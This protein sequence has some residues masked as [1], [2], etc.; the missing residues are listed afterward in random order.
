VNGLLS[1]HYFVNQ[2]Q[3]DMAKKPAAVFNRR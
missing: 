2:L 1:V 3:L